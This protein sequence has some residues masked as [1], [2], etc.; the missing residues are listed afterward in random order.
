CAIPTSTIVCRSSVSCEGPGQASRFL[1]N[2][3]LF[4]MHEQ[5]ERGWGKN[6]SL[7]ARTI[8]DF[9]S[10]SLL[11]PIELQG[12]TGGDG[13]GIGGSLD[14]GIPA[15]DIRGGFQCPSVSDGDLGSIPAHRNSRG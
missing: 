12:L 5:N 11:G 6:S 13:V 8:R 7:F 9:Y 1:A 4:L 2:R 10:I 3:N 14:C 15:G